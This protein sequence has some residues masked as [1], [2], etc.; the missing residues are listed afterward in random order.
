MQ[1]SNDSTPNLSRTNLQHH[2]EYDLNE[3][4]Q[5]VPMNRNIEEAAYEQEYH[6]GERSKGHGK[7]VAAGL[8][9][10]AAG[11]LAVNAMRHDD[12]DIDDDEE[13]MYY[14]HTQHVPS[15]L[16]YVPYNQEKR[17]LSFAV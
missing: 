16:K 6:D 15:P 2:D 13:D 5:K 3:H 12:R 1:H 10:A 14:Q 9:G 4:G 17:G 8:A 7:A 11:A